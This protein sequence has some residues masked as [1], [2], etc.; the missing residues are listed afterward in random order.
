MVANV[1]APDDLRFSVGR[2][3]FVTADAQPKTWCSVWCDKLGVLRMK[4]K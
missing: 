2:R 1:L 3:I 4:A